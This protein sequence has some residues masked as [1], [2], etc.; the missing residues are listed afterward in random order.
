MY[1]DLVRI[2]SVQPKDDEINVASE[3]EMRIRK[4]LHYPW[5]TVRGKAGGQSNQ[6]FECKVLGY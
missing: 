5:D 1:L 6:P 2:Q 3:T 4:R